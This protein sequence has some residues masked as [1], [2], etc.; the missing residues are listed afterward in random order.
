MIIGID[1]GATGGIAWLSDSGRLIEV[2]DLP[3]VKVGSR[4]RLMPAVL[5]AWLNETDRRP[6]HA[7][8]E[9][10]ES[11]PGEGHAGAFSFGRNFGGIEGV[12]AGVG[13]AVTMVRPQIWKRDL[14]IP[15]GKT[16]KD[17]TPSRV[18][19]AQCWPGQA[20]AFARVKDDGR[21]ESALIGLYGANSMQ[22]SARSSA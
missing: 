13:V 2:R 9:E 22:G 4:T 19:A 16:P 3:V 20:G 12:L 21:A 17:K 5:A 14:R 15:K 11:R 10:V 8:I 1:P 6:I 18:R 7:F